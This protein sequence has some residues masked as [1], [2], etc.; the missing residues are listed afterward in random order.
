MEEEYRNQVKEHKK[1]LKEFHES[2]AE[3]SDILE[4]I[5]ID[6]R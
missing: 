2:F 4:K 1:G 6:S 5:D 3:D